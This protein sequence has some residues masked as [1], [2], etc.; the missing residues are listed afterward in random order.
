MATK[1]RGYSTRQADVWALGIVLYN[2]VTACNPWDKAV[3]ADLNFN[4]YLG[5]LPS[6]AYAHILLPTAPMAS[7][8]D[9]CITRRNLSGQPLSW[10]ANNLFRDIFAID[11]QQRPSLKKIR[12][13]VESLGTFFQPTRPTLATATP[14]PTAL[15][16]IDAASL[17]PS[18]DADAVEVEAAPSR[19]PSDS[20]SPSNTPIRRRPR[21]ADLVARLR[22]NFEADTPT[23]S[24]SDSGSDASDS[25][26]EGPITPTS[27]ATPSGVMV[28]VLD[29]EQGGRTVTNKPKI[30][31]QPAKHGD[32]VQAQQ[33]EL[34]PVGWI[35]RYL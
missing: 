32:G 1:Q 22:R 31:F 24:G 29:L 27:N 19:P 26:S 12:A 8:S 25:D 10:T 3:T 5:S 35:R 21:I 20:A 13:R 6:H 9:V 7:P 11:P 30:V 23:R 17:S 16:L 15:S 14:T 33:L 34:T 18:C 4:A 2:L 28:P